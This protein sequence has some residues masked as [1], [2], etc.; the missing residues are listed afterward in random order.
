[1][2]LPTV[3]AD[4]DPRLAIEVEREDLGCIPGKR[5]V[6]GAADRRPGAPQQPRADPTLV[7][8]RFV[9]VVA[10]MQE[11]VRSVGPRRSRDPERSCRRIRKLV[12]GEVLINEWS[13]SGR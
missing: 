13:V 5:Y 2:V 12:S 1:M 8:D 7:L 10:R 3:G 9:E 4:T 11:L 6:P